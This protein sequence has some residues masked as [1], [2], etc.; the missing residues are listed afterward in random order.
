[1]LLYV[2]IRHVD[3]ILNIGMRVYVW[4]RMKMGHITLK[5]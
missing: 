5:L 3:P 1:M 2:Y 4:K